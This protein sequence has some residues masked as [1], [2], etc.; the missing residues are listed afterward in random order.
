MKIYGYFPTRL[1]F[2]RGKEAAVSSC[3][4]VNQGG[5]LSRVVEHYRV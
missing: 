3:R 2:G 5:D 1:G 4:Y